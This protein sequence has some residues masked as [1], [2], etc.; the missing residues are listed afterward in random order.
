MTSTPA[1]SDYNPASPRYSS[2]LS[3]DTG[4]RPFLKRLTRLG[5]IWGMWTIVAL[6]FSTQIFMMYYSERQPIPYKRAFLVQ[7]SACYLWALVTP[8]ILWLSRRFR[9][10]RDNWLRKV[11]LHL[12]FSLA[13]VTVLISLHFVVYMMLT[14]RASS[15]TP[16]RLMGYLYPNL[17]RW[18][19]VYWVI[20]L[21]SHAFNYYNSYR[22]GELKASQLRTQLV[23]SQLEALKMQVQPHFLFNTLHSISA[24]LS[25]DTEGARKMITRLGDFLRLTLENS[26]SMEVTLQQEIEFLNGY[27]EI[28][29]I[30][31]QDRLTTDIKIDPAVLEA[32]VPNLILQPIV[33]NAMKH[34][35]V[36]SRSG[37]VE[38]TAAPRNGAVHIEVKDNGPG[39]Q[40]DRTLEA[41]RGKGLGLANTQARLIGLYGT[42]ARFEMTNRPSGG[43]IVSIDIPRHQRSLS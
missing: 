41:R 11:A 43:L 14:G 30:R 19:L 21:M 4:P 22:K 2:S 18:L 32:R 8:L 3:D 35:V 5:I 17:D 34:A 10:E 31:F 40:V 36:N 29:R 25:K 26:G 12:L 15:I 28:E 13:L 20:L 39:L 24:L 37:H 16:L 9:I 38:I 7:G 27:L 23:Q 42:D 33:E 1:I 6:F